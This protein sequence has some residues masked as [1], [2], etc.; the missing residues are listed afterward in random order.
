M[1]Y[2]TDAYELFSGKR[3]VDGKPLSNADRAFAGLGLFTLGAS[4]YI[5]TAGKI[6][7]KMSKFGLGDYRK[8]V[9]SGQKIINSASKYG[10]SSLEYIKVYAKSGVEKNQAPMK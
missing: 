4:N 5:K 10:A 3:L 8:A 9:Y 2:I 7:S 6:L 1:L